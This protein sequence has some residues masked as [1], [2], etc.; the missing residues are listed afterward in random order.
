MFYEA[1]GS[2]V[3]PSG[4]KFLYSLFLPIWFEERK[5][6]SF[7]FYFLKDLNNMLENS[8][9]DCLTKV[10]SLFLLSVY[11]SLSIFSFCFN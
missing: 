4:I 8:L 10:Y 1:F 3:I 9:E 2:Y 7:Y 11:H 6:G 5:A